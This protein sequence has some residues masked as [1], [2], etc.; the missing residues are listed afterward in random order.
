MFYLILSLLVL[1]IL[2]LLAPKVFDTFEEL[3]RTVENLKTRQLIN[4]IAHI[5]WPITVCLCCFTYIFIETLMRI[6]VRNWTRN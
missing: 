3:L 2:G 5:F 6:Y 4:I 1:Y